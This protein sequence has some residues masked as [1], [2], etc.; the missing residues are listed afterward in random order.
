MASKVAAAAL[1]GWGQISILQMAGVRYLA[2]GV[3]SRFSKMVSNGEGWKF[4][5]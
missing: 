4:E 5:I 2:G 1:P 3:R